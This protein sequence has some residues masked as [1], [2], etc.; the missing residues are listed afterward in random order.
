MSMR[1]YELVNHLGN[2]QATVLDR[3][4]PVLSQG[5]VLTGYKADLSS[6]QDYFPFGMLMPG[7]YLSDTAAHCVTLNSTVMVEK[8]IQILVSPAGVKTTAFLFGQPVPPS[9]GS[10][11]LAA[12]F[13]SEV[14]YLYHYVPAAQHPGGWAAKSSAAPEGG[15]I[16]ELELSG[17]PSGITSFLHLHMDTSVQ[18]QQFSFGLD[19]GRN[20]SGNP[21]AQVRVRQYYSDSTEQYR[22]LVQWRSVTNNGASLLVPV[23]KQLILAGGKTVVEWKFNSSD[24]KSFASGTTVKI[25]RPWTVRT[26]W[27]AANVVVRICD[28]KDNYRFGFNGMEKDNEVKGLGNSLDFG[29]RM[30]DS[31]LGRFTSVDQ[32]A[33]SFAGISPYLYAQNSPIA[34]IDRGGN[35]GEVIISKGNTSSNDPEKRKAT[36]TANQIYYTTVDRV[37]ALGGDYSFF[38]NVKM[39][40]MSGSSGGWNKK[41]ST[42][43]YNVS[44]N[45]TVVEPLKSEANLNQ[46]LTDNP[47]ANYLNING[48]YSNA[49]GRFMFFDPKQAPCWR[50]YL[51]LGWRQFAAWPCGWGTGACSLAIAQPH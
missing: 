28:E 20:A 18:T 13:A 43:K 40:D 12:D 9:V 41:W 44:F 31:R 46:M 17:E 49:G 26:Q 32:L 51:S 4:T 34:M 10:L 1:H 2:V 16:Y 6:A 24:G 47:V 5:Q 14:L 27:V 37:K 42:D 25:I 36:V 11:P 30:Y 23:D 7:R 3:V 35:H 38:D 29:A 33:K 48:M 45:Q 19:L 21:S 15:L 8:P 39:N 50:G 22:E